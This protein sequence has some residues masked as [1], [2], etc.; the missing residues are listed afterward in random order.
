M[1]VTVYSVG[2]QFL[3]L[4]VKKGI[5]CIKGIGFLIINAWIDV[6]RGIMLWRIMCVIGV[7]WGVLVVWGWKKIC[8]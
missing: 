8:V 6:L 3:V 2:I 4:C 1:E 7:M 5:F